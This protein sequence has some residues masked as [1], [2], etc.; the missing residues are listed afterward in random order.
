[1]TDNTLIK[2]LSKIEEMARHRHASVE[3]ATGGLVGNINAALD[4]T[5]SEAERLQHVG[6]AVTHL[7]VLIGNI[8]GALNEQAHATQELA[9][10]AAEG[11]RMDMEELNKSLVKVGERDFLG[12]GRKPS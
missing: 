6:F 5:I 11:F 2:R 12:K 9:A 7:A 8:A 1:M 4:T 3:D 10:Y